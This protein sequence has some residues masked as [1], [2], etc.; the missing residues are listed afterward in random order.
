MK[1]KNEKEEKTWKKISIAR[2]VT[3]ANFF[4]PV[5]GIN[6]LIEQKKRKEKMQ[7]QREAFIRDACNEA[8]NAVGLP[9]VCLLKTCVIRVPQ[10]LAKVMTYY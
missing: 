3:T 10:A 4:P 7:C 8:C 6:D 5:C 1:R 9:F 2:C